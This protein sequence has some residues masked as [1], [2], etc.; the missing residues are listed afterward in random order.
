MLYLQIRI[1]N[2]VYNE[3]PP[4]KDRRQGL[5]ILLKTSV[6]GE[7]GDFTVRVKLNFSNQFQTWIRKIFCLYLACLARYHHLLSPKIMKNVSPTNH[8]KFHC[9]QNPRWSFL[10]P[11]NMDILTPNEAQLLFET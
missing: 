7:G 9:S 6:L 5:R 8:P 2:S 11:E 10:D 1:W 4:P 3:V